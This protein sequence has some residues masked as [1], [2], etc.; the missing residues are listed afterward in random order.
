MATLIDRGGLME[1]PGP[2]VSYV[3]VSPQGDHW[4]K[5]RI[6]HS[7]RDTEVPTAADRLIGSLL[8]KRRDR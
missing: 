8:P 6:T 7:A 1:L 5:W 4:L 3:V 2:G